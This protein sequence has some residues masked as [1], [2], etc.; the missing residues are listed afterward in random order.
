VSHLSHS[1][2]AFRRAY[3]RFFLAV[4]S[5][6][7]RNILGMELIHE[8]DGGDFTNFFLAFPEEGKE[9]QSEEEKSARKFQREGV[10]E[11]CHNH[12]HPADFPGYCNGNTDPGRGAYFPLLPGR[13]VTGIARIF[14]FLPIPACP[15]LT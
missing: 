10:L 15:L 13:R 5:I 3:S 7:N 6:F 1:S 9:N 2:H 14:L 12:E 4:F 11:L 8:M